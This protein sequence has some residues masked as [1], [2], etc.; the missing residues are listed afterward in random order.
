MTTVIC[1]L[2]EGYAKIAIVWQNQITK[3]AKQ[4]FSYLRNVLLS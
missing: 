1:A 4:A 3:K 2:Q